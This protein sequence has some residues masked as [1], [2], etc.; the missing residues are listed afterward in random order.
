MYIGN[1]CVSERETHTEVSGKIGIYPLWFK[2]SSGPKINEQDAS[3][4]LISALIPAML[5][6]ENIVVGDD[7]YVSEMLYK[8]LAQIQA[9]INCWNPV[10]K[11][12]K[13]QA[14]LTSRLPAKNRTASF[15]S[16]GVD[17]LY[18]LAMNHD[19]IDDIILINGFDFNMD[20]LAWEN[21]IERNERVAR[22]FNKKLITVETNL[23]EFNSWFRLARY[24]NFGA[25]LATIAQFQDYRKVFISSSDTYRKLLPLGAHP[26]LDPLWSTEACDLVHVG[27]EADRAKKIAAIKRFPEALAELWVCWK[28]PTANCGE[29]SK[30]IRSYIA[31]RLNGVD[32]FNFLTPITLND[33]SK[34]SIEKEE[35]LSFFDD[36]RQFASANNFPEIEKKLNKMILSYKIKTFV[37]DVD[38][39][40]FGSKI[41]GY[42]RK[43]KVEERGLSDISVVPNY[44]DSIILEKLT[45]SL[46]GRQDFKSEISIGTRFK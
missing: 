8:N 25:S 27:L 42:R 43:G 23:K 9:I 38:R 7:Y 11:I 31:L 28:D 36:L 34:I 5:L 12:I 10:F 24:A 14:R 26:L 33:L 6:G 39:Y 18:T 45:S 17:S 20:S 2:F 46:P 35:S 1:I 29:C 40:L 41:S 19:E 22:I 4:F 30:C 37:K 32:D 44:G 21:M 3:P 16:G 15:C 13:I